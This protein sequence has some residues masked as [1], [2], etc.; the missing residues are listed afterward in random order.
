MVL[1]WVVLGV[2]MV[3]EVLILLLLM[4]LGLGGM[5][6]GLIFVVRIVLQLLFVVVFLLFFLVFEIYWKYEYLIV[7]EGF[8]C[9]FMERDCVFKLVMKSQWNVIFVGVVLLLYWILYCVIVMMV[10]MEQFSVQLKKIKVLDKV[11]QVVSFFFQCVFVYVY[12]RVLGIS[13]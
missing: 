3:V 2:V 6:R 7:C 12:F 8:Q 1:E 10:K 9:G 5:W 4:M 13:L 11:E